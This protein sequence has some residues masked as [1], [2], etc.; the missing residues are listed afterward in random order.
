MFVRIKVGLISF[1]TAGV[2]LA[3]SALTPAAAA[4]AVYTSPSTLTD[5][6]VTALSTQG[7]GTGPVLAEGQTLG[8]LFDNPFATERGELFILQTLNAGGFARAQIR[9]GVYNNGAPTFIF[10]RN[11]FQDGR[12]LR[13]RNLYQR[14]C[15]AFGGCDY[16]EIIT[17]ETRGDV[18]GFSVDYVNVDGQI[19]DVAAPTPEPSTWALMIAAFA[20][21]AWRLKAMR[22]GGSKQLMRIP[23]LSSLSSA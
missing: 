6:E 12:R 17:T 5:A 3:V 13:I 7:D 11:N 15:S 21:V 8:L 1:L 22:R 9:I 19:A 18:E 20:A 10:T 23:Q 14:G 2:C 16:I 4:T